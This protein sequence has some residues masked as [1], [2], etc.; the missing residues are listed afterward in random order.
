MDLTTTTTTQPE[1]ALF[2]HECCSSGYRLLKEF[3][4]ANPNVK[5]EAVT[6]FNVK[7]KGYDTKYGF[8]MDELKKTS[9]IVHNGSVIKRN[10]NE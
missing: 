3:K 8:T 5:V 4:I 9:Y 7:E 2:L 10:N 6:Y 1:T